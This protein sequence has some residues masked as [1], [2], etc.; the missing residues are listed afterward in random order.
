MTEPN[1]EIIER[2]K[3]AF[4]GGLLAEGILELS[5]IEQE[6]PLVQALLKRDEAMVLSL[7]QEGADPN[8]CNKALR[9]RDNFAGEPPL[10]HAIEKGY[11]AIAKA[12]LDHG[13]DP[14]YRPK[15]RSM[16]IDAIAGRHLDCAELLLQ[17]GANPNGGGKKAVRPLEQAVSSCSADAFHLLLKYGA[18]PLLP[19]HDGSSVLF[20][21]LT[22]YRSATAPLPGPLGRV[23]SLVQKKEQ[24]KVAAT[25]MLDA[26]LALPHD[27][28]LRGRT[29]ATALMVACEGAEIEVV[30]RVLELGPDLEAETN[31]RHMEPGF[32]AVHFAMLRDRDDVL[33]LLITA[34]ANVRDKGRAKLTPDEY[35]KQCEAPR[36]LALLNRLGIG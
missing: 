30:R 15:H 23:V 9:N 19:S 17:R 18:D 36:C 34:G 21:V 28:N 2:A 35:A 7:L 26:M 32:R 12:L 3:Q 20:S 29:G 8:A 27:V 33:Q 11:A 31:S 13:A 14:D 6:P 25:R 24:E 10:V 1:D 5:P 4:L 22:A 16:L